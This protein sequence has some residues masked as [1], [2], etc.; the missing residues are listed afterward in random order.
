MATCDDDPSNSASATGGGGGDTLQSPQD[1]VS[2]PIFA[3]YQKIP[4]WKKELIQKRKMVSK[5]VSD[6]PSVQS[7]DEG[8]F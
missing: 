1:S 8:K 5:V 3:E 7:F 2:G 6:S 4:D